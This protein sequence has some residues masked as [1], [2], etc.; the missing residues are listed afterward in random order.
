MICAVLLA[1]AVTAQ[2]PTVKVTD[3]VFLPGFIAIRIF[4]VPQPPDPPGTTQIYHPRNCA[5]A[6]WRKLLIINE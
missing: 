6:L 4:C 2:I 5:A 3:I 1:R